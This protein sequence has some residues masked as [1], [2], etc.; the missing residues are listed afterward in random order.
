[1]IIENFIRNFWQGKIKLWQSFWLVGGIGGI[2][3]FNLIIFIED[4]IFSNSTEYLTELSFRS[5]LL[6]LIWT[7]F[8]TVG[9]WRSAE[10]YN[11][12]AFL[13]ILTKFYIPANCL[14]SVYILFF[15]KPLIN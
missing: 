2:L 7:I 15:L 1:M 5:K 10:N 14:S 11:G 12:Y 8:Y 13:K 9:I 3:I 6:V 4:K